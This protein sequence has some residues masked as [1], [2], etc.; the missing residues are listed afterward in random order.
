M[1]PAADGATSPARS[2]RAI[3]LALAFGVVSIAALL[4]WQAPGGSVGASTR[5]EAPPAAASPMIAVLPFADLSDSGDQAYF[6]DRPAE[7]LMNALS[8]VPG[9]RVIGR[10]SSFSFGTDGDGAMKAIITELARRNV[11]RVGIAY[12][13]MAWL[14][15][16]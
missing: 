5:I 8:H 2:S 1:A 15:L 6:S 10:T 12:P 13:A 16:Q 9:L 7:E 4:L 14:I 3:D 11:I